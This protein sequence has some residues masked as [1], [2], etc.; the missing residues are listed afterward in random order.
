M[1]RLN[2]W[3]D[4]LPV[5]LGKARL[6]GPSRPDGDRLGGS[7][8]SKVNGRSLRFNRRYLFEGNFPHVVIARDVA[9]SLRRPASISR[10]IW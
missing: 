3:I 6:R 5:E 4:F 8:R 9:P 1:M 10:A 7:T 2:R